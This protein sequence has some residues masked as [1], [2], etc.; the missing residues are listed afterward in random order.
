MFSIVKFHLQLKWNFTKAFI[1][2][3]P[4][5]NSTN[6]L[7]TLYRER[8]TLRYRKVQESIVHCH[9]LFLCYMASRTQ[10]IIKNVQSALSLKSNLNI[11]AILEFQLKN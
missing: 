3:L 7:L 10:I 4:N 11:T 8:P 5:R 1:S 2:C 9:H 6:K